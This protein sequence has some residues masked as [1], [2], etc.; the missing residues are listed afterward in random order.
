MKK[1]SHDGKMANS[2]LNDL[3]KPRTMCKPSQTYLLPA[4]QVD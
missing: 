3:S 2:S 4:H 1:D